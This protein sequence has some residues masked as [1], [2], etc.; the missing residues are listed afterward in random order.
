M[1]L[2]DFFGDVLGETVVS[3]RTFS[4]IGCCFKSDGIG[5]DFS[6]SNDFESVDSRV[7]VSEHSLSLSL[8]LPHSD[9]PVQH[10]VRGLMALNDVILR[11]SDWSDRNR[12]RCWMR[13]HRRLNLLID[14][15][16]GFESE[17]QSGSECRWIW[18]RHC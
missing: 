3:G 14:L 4:E 15:S 7:V 17:K 10:S 1:S 5:S 6:D 16:S 11:D 13:C 18:D 2:V 8:C 9:P 12:H